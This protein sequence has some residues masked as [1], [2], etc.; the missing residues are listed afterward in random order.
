MNLLHHNFFDIKGH[1]SAGG[2]PVIWFSIKA[3]RRLQ[4]PAGAL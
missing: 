2:S 3:L 1:F 4:D